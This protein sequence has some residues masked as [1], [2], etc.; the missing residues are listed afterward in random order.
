MF[1]RLFEPIRIGK[2]ET[3]VVFKFR[4]KRLLFF[5]PAYNHESV[6]RS[7]PFRSDKVN[8]FT[9]LFFE[10]SSPQLFPILHLLDQF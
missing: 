4:K 10:F 7:F 2:V 5:S 8:P 3:V 9:D 6:S 1:D